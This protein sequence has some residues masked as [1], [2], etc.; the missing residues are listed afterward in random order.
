MA[1]TGEVGTGKTTLCQCLLQQLPEQVN[2]ALILNPKLDAKDLVASICDELSIVYDKSET[3]LKNLL[4]QLNLFLL[5]ANAQGQ[6]TV[7]MID[8]AQNLSFDVLEQ[9]R[10]LTNLE[11]SKHKL[12]QIILIGQPEL[13]ELLQLPKLR[14]LNQRVTARF[15]LLP[16]TEFESEQYIKHRLQVSQGDANLFNKSCCRRIYQ[17]SRGIPRLINV[18]CD[19]ALLGAYVND[20]HK[21]ALQHVNQAAREVDEGLLKSQP[22]RQTVLLIV[23]LASMLGASIY[24]YSALNIPGVQQEAVKIESLVQEKQKAKQAINV[25]VEPGQPDVKP[26]AESLSAFLQRQ[27]PDI[28]QS[29]NA[30]AKQWGVTTS[31]VEECGEWGLECMAAQG[32]W[33]ELLALNRPVILE[34]QL[35]EKETYHLLMTGVESGNPVFVLNDQTAVFSLFD[36]LQVW[37]GLFLLVWQ[38]PSQWDGALYPGQSSATVDWLRQQL[39]ENEDYNSGNE[40]H[41][42]DSTLQS[43]VKEFQ[44]ANGLLVDGIVGP[45]TIIQMQNQ[46]VSDEPRL[47]MSD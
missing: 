9:V 13:Q 26:E 22:G 36:V 16:L 23:L 1:L 43:R 14:Q 5:K 20:Q 3:S 45:R 30:L 47:V 6:R 19:R 24:H 2:L 31:S 17:L 18:L 37:R 11:T 4:D 38:P 29:F 15:H 27:Q 40:S 34:L 25:P 21:V 35:S 10:L 28:N 7:L 8:E 42:F 32:D 41:V 12:L 39:V 46:F 44:R 33:R